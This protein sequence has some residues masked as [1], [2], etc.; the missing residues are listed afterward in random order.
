MSDLFALLPNIVSSLDWRQPLWLLLALQPLFLWLVLR[1]LQKYKQTQF[2]DSHL[3]PW[4][5]VKQKQK[6]GKTLF[7]R[8]VAYGLAWVLLAL[9]LAGPRVPDDQQLGSNNG[10]EVLVDIMMVIDLS[11][12]MHAIDII[13]SRIRRASLEAYELLSL[14]KNTRMGIVVYAARPHLFVPLTTDKSALKFY[15]QDLDSLQLPTKGSDANAALAF[16]KKELQ[17]SSVARKQVI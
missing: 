17:A 5:K 8:D 15:L 1:W 13:P 3:L 4:I 11:R 9:S 12:S 14:V 2:A 16:A 6:L 7:S 10:N